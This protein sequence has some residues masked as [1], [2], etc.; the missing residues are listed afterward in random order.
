MPCPFPDPR[1]LAQFG[2]H[3][4]FRAAEAEESGAG[5]GGTAAVVA[6]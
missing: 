6:G 1:L 2:R 3:G 5:T 4:Q